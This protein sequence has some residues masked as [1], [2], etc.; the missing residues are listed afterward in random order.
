MGIV[1]K[2]FFDVAGYPNY[3]NVISNI[4]VDGV[5]YALNDS[6]KATIEPVEGLI[7]I[8][9]ENNNFYAIDKN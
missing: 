6:S 5:T 4:K 1:H 9:P 7:S 3:E 8:S 2:T